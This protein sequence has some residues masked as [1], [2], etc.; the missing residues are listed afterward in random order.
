[1]SQPEPEPV[2]APMRLYSPLVEA[3]VRLAA[4]GHYHQFRKSP[5]DHPCCDK[6]ESPLPD[7][8]IPYVTHL[9]GTALILARL[10]VRDEVL[11]AACLHDYL[12]DVP[13]PEGARTIREAVGDDVL[14]LVLAVTEN[15]RRDRKESETWEVRK[16]EQV[17]R[18]RQAPAEAVLVKSADLLHNLHSLLSDLRG[19]A[20][21]GQVWERLTAGPDRQLWYFGAVLD[22]ARERLVDHPLLDELTAAVDEART[23]T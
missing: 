3:A 8:C 13:D 12:E 20:R 7:G 1:M 5:L 17:Q 14:S 23:F 10:G 4:K 19:A 9:M 6:A 2:A 11:A 15:K 21:P 18:L 16:Q 22:A